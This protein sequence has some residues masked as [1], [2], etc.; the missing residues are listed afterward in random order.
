MG[1]YW[2]AVTTDSGGAV[3]EQNSVAQRSRIDTTPLTIDTYNVQIQPP[4]QINQAGQPVAFMGTA[5]DSLTHQPAADV[6]VA[7]Q[8][9]TGGTVRIIVATTDAGGKFATAFQPLATE[10]GVYQYGAGPADQVTDPPIGQFEIVGMTISSQSALNVA[11]GVPLSGSA[12]V[13]NLSPVPLTGLT[14]DV[15]DA[16]ANIQVQVSLGS[17]TLAGSGTIPLNFVITA[18]NTL[19]TQANVLILVQSNEG[20]A[21]VLTLPI[22][23]IPLAPRLVAQPGTI[24][25][26]MVPGNQQLV[27]F[28][29]TNNGGAASGPVQVAIPQAPWLSLIS[30]ATIGSLAPGQSAT[31]TLQLLPAA[32]LPLGAYTGTISVIGQAA[33]LNVP[34]QFQAMSTATGNLEVDAQDEFTFYAQGSPLVDDASVVLKDLQTGAVVASGTTGAD[35]KLVLNQIP[36][37]TYNLLV[38]AAGHNDY[39]GSVTVQ[40]GQLNVADAFMTRQLVTYKWNVTKD[41]IQDTYSFTVD[42]TFQTHVPAPVVTISP[43]Y[44][45]FSKL[46]ADTT[47]I[48]FTITNHG[49]IAADDVSLSFDSNAMYQV[50]PLVG[51][52]GTLAAMSEIVVPVIIH[53]NATASSS[54][55]ATPAV[56]GTGDCGSGQVL[57]NVWCENKKWYSEAIGYVNYSA[58]C[59]SG[60][61]VLVFI[62]ASGGGPLLTDPG[63]GDDFSQDYLCDPVAQGRLLKAGGDILKIGLGLYPPTAPWVHLYD[64]VNFAINGPKNP[65]PATINLLRTYAEGPLGDLG[66]L[67]LDLQEANNDLHGT[68]APEV[69]SASGLA[70]TASNNIA[71]SAATSSSDPLTQL[72]VEIGRIQTIVD[73]FTEVFGSPV[74]QT[75]QDSSQQP[76]LVSWLQAFLQDAADASGNPR[77]INSAQQTQLLALP[78]PAPVQSSDA[79]NFIARWNNTVTYNALGIINLADVP[80]GQTTNF[81]AMDVLQAKFLAA[82][83][84]ANSL[85]SEGYTDLNDAILTAAKSAYNAFAAQSDLGICATAH[86]QI[87]QQATVARSAFDASLELDNQEPSDSLQNVSINLDI[88]DLAG[89]DVTNM[90]F[91]SSPTLTGLSAVDGSGMLSADSNGT[92]DWT[93]IPTNAAAASGITRYLVSGTLSYSD[94]GV[95]FTSPLLSTTIDVYPDPSLNVQYFVQ[96]DVYGD[97]PFT[98]QVETP[99]PFALG[100]MVTNTGPG[101]A[102]NFTITSAQPKIVDNQK[103]LLV[104][105]NIIGAQVGNQPVSPTLT[106]DLGTIASGQTAVAD[107]LTTSSLDGQFLS[108]DA[109]YQHDSALGGTATSIIDSVTA[110]DM[111]HLVQPNRAGDNGDPAFLV[112]SNPTL[113]P[114]PDTLYLADG[115]TAAVS[116]ASNPAVDGAVTGSHLQ[117]HL[118]A[119]M[120]S[121]WDYLQMPDPGVGYKLVKVVRSDGAQILVGP[122]AWTTHPVDSSTQSDPNDLLHLVDFNGTG[123]YTLYYLPAN[124]QPPV[125]TAL[126]PVSPNPA[127]G[128]ISSTDVTLSEEVDAATFDPSKLA[129]TLNGGANLITAGVTFTQ[130]SG[131]TYQ[132]GGLAPLT[133]PAG[134]YELTV[135]PGLVQDSAGE[136]STGALS[137]KWANGQVGPYVVTIDNVTPDPRNTPVDSVNVQ[138]DEPIEATSFDY[139]DVSLTLNGGTNLINSSVTITQVAGLP[140]TYAIGGLSSLT[141]TEGKYDLAVDA[142]DITDSLDQSGIG[143]SDTQWTSDLTPPQLLSMQPVATNPRNTVVM[144]LD[145]T[146][147][148]AID[149]STVTRD[150]LTLTRNGGSNL[151]DDRVQITYL[152][153]NTYQ[154]TGFNWVVGQEGNYVLTANGNG[155]QDLAGNVGAGTAS[156]SWV[157]DITPPAVPTNVVV[158]PGSSVGANSWSTGTT[159]DLVT[160]T[161]AETGLSVSLFDLT[162]LQSLGDATVTG[163]S[164]SIP[165]ILPSSGNHHLQIA[166]VDPA[167]N[168]TDSDLFIS[169]VSATTTP[170]VLLDAPNASYTAVWTDDGPVAIANPE[171]LAVIDQGSADL[172]AITVALNSPHAGD[173]LSTNTSGTNISASYNPAAGVLTLTGSD[174]LADYQQVLSLVTYDNSNGDPLVGSESVTVLAND[175]ESTSTVVACAIDINAPPVVLLNAPNIGYVSIWTMAGPVTI[176]NA[177]NATINDGAGRNLVSLAIALSHPHPGDVLD[178]NVSGTNITGSYNA[179]AG[180]LTLSG[181]DSVVDYQKVL[182][183]ITYDNTLGGSGVGSE[184]FSVVADD[185]ISLGTP[186]VG[187]IY[188]GAPTNSTVAGVDLFYNQSKFDSNTAGVSLK[189]D[190]AIDP[191]KTGYLAGTGA[192]TFANLSGYVDG[193]N[194][195]MVDLTIGGLHG[196]ISIADF[197]F[198]LGANNSPSTWATAPAP[199]I[200]SVRSG[201]GFGGADRV[202]LIWANDAIKDTWL[203]VTVLA[204]AD[205]GLTAPYTFFYGSLIG[206]T[207]AANSPKLAIVNSSDENAIRDDSG[208]AAVTNVFDVNKDGFVNSSDESAARANSA[209][210]KF[211][212]IAANTPLA[213]DA[214]PAVAPAITLAPALTSAGE[215]SGTFSGDSGIASGLASLLGSLKSGTLPPLRLDLLP[216]ELTH[217]NLNS[218]AA[219][220]IFEA[221]AAA[222]TKLT[223]SILVE[224]DEVADKLGLDDE[225]LDSILVDL[226]LA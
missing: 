140:N 196:S 129:L 73:A 200:V 37:G 169:V 17:M 101:D 109:S 52:L 28:N 158:T 164:F 180:M 90:F 187:T 150:N 115:T 189:D 30:P 215:F 111:I 46:T 132:I 160:G 212:K 64:L 40:T 120:T 142:T 225:L 94:N 57:W 10:A 35:G 163:T 112:D 61:P 174:T 141:A 32:D 11:P 224:D 22:T 81:I 219:A 27:T 48:D 143:A 204:D 89:N 6:P 5:Y 72:P 70:V 193:I 78:L 7:V 161:L 51:S 146:F 33:S 34:F 155:V 92:A 83:N 87:N 125:V 136:L 88:H 128:P 99:Q 198:K 147:S 190:R 4:A 124:A 14:T 97:D 82:Q 127:S 167:G 223:R 58:Q 9:M 41:T 159:S 8:I 134:V 25:S 217:V 69:L 68:A 185:G 176:T 113:S 156:A 24:I 192:A 114:L 184:T 77:V 116:L 20:A 201:A 38:Q 122:D 118:T 106:A 152:S 214:A 18:T 218:G 206:D 2:L 194:G 121:G 55:T 133:A 191:T 98:P 50:T 195:I 131:T 165:V 71:A 56:G 173:V 45:D 208:A 182:T 13:S 108:Y 80:S 31:V 177:A 213:P 179:S 3:V 36:V 181:G 63:A 117:V 207:G 16:P 54:L 154:I 149:L 29:V 137:E 203:E 188:M 104:D 144:S 170:T 110:H 126:A 86:L 202:E 162:T 75:L 209:T 145:V 76:V 216:S 39:Q 199:T 21:Q 123:S 53:R 62:G 19:V 205:T 44:I 135:S 172:I 47:E 151:I 105:F 26:G 67:L 183:S 107:W 166:T 130:V 221:L 153:G 102:G 49:L 222:D 91:I 148:E 23:V 211:I 93:I 197:E 42:T 138:F 59:P 100:I 119:N 66:N 65:G 60:Y 186:A 139:H 84:A 226:G 1:Q 103:G 43:A 220:M 171:T 15:I 157:V 95:T 210:L 178:A 96:H 12:T 175:G 79:A 168:E 74:W 85:Q